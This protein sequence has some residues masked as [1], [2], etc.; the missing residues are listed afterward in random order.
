MKTATKNG[1]NA[2]SMPDNAL[3]RQALEEIERIEAEAKQKK[4]AQLD[5][6]KSARAAILE[7]MNEL[8]HQL[9]QIDAAIASVTGQPAP[10]KEKRARRNW[11]DDQQRVGR[12]LQGRKGEKFSAGDLVRE[13]PELDGQPVSI[14]LKPLVEMGSIKTDATE[15]PRRTKYFAEG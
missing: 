11:A 12:W 8:G 15:G 7:R 5:G 1:R 10:S 3:A 13:F 4:M 6:L 9:K 2:T 14:F